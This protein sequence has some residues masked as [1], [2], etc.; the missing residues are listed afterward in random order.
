MIRI[1]FLASNP[2]DTSALA[3]EEEFGVVRERL[4]QSPKGHLF[5]LAM[6][7]HANVA[8]LHRVLYKHRPH[9]VHFAGHGNQ[10]GE[11]ILETAAGAAGAAVSREGLI[12]LFR[13]PPREPRRVQCVV[14]N[15]CFT[16]AVAQGIAESVPCVVGMSNEI[17]DSSAGW[18]AAGFYEAIG[19]G[20]TVG[21]AV[22]SGRHRIQLAE[23][24][25]PD[26][27]RLRPRLLTYSVDPWK[28]IIRD[29]VQALRLGQTLHEKYVIVRS[30]GVGLIA[31]L[32]IALDLQLERR[33]VVKTLV[34]PAAR[35]AFERE[36]HELA[37]V[38]KH[39][40]IVTVYGAWLNDD[41]P[42][43]VREYIEGH[44][45][46]DEL[47]LEGRAQLPISFIHQVLVAAG[48]AM[49][50][51]ADTGVRDLGV[52]PEKILLQ[53]RLD[54]ATPGGTS[55]YRVIVVP[56]PGGSDYIRHVRPE[57]LTD[58]S[59]R[60]V[61]PE[62]FRGDRLWPATDVDRANQYR[63]GLLGYEML[64]GSEAFRALAQGRPAGG[65]A[66]EWPP[67]EPAGGDRPCPGFLRTAIERMVRHRPADRYESLEAA[68]EALTNRNLNVEVARD[69]F[70]RI[71]DTADHGFSFFHAFYS[72]LV[73][74]E[75]V[76]QAFL[77]SPLGHLPP[78]DQLRPSDDSPWARQFAL[79]EEAVVLLFAHNLLR[80]FQGPSILDRVV[81]THAKWVWRP[82]QYDHFVE[83]LIR[84][85]LKVDE[86]G[87]YPDE[88]ETAWRRAVGP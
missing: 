61:P 86:G 16:D 77:G 88:L 53:R 11:L 67:V 52:E 1:L 27:D 32:D 34:E 6:E 7:R 56:G 39:P 9:I 5:E 83:A 42:H 25:G 79:L 68:V 38:S 69:S 87:H 72:D 30:R 63:L 85:V 15:A 50:Y 33:V 76:R 17:R 57:R 55:T 54:R 58:E 10:R 62:Q 47:D 80:D 81:R 71:L 66:G 82:E 84:T 36:V 31:S 8:D 13:V 73:A 78:A 49:L 48:D 65:S 3:L 24:A 4:A 45:L 43:Y 22:G 46:R 44:S 23:P 70:R 35:A 41:P 26:P 12:E 29:G 64:V 59:R 18:F 75:A 20:R 51:A 60:Y 74:N 14:L 37:R 2:T 40:N 21:E 28:Y 19:F